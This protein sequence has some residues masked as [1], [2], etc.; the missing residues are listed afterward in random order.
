MMA[1][2]ESHLM[3]TLMKESLSAISKLKYAFYLLVRVLY[4]SKRKAYPILLQMDYSP[5]QLDWIKITLTKQ[6]IS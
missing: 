3:F 5:L 1:D 6:P 4:A 2:R